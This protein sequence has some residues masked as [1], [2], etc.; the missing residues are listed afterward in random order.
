M[1]K[2]RR[3][4]FLRIAFDK[5]RAVVHR[6]PW[7]AVQAMGGMVGTKAGGGRSRTAPSG[8]DAEAK[9]GDLGRASLASRAAYP[10]HPGGEGGHMDGRKAARALVVG[11]VISGLWSAGFATNAGAGAIDFEILKT[12]NGT[13]PPGTVFEVT[14]AC[15]EG[16]TILPGGQENG[17]NQAVVR[18]D[19]A[20]A[21]QDP[22]AFRF[23]GEGTC[24][25]TETQTGG[26]SAVTYECFLTAGETNGASPPCPPSGPQTDP[27][28]LNVTT[29]RSQGSV[30]VTNTFE[31]P[32]PAPP[33]P[34]VTAPARFTG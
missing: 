12:V 13:P 2:S 11:V 4:P 21:A 34:P 24:T 6:A 19:A 16:V 25:V 15:Q 1:G 26:A 10:G 5:P 33:A 20:G 29:P 27:P 23:E 3:P 18:F 8:A 30:V 14:L 9:G 17:Q 31:A 22:S 28:T 32:Q 7:R